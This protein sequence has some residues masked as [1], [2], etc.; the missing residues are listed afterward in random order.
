MANQS[1][2]D[3]FGQRSVDQVNKVKR[4]VCIKHNCPYLT[5]TDDGHSNYKPNTKAWLNNKC[6]NFSLITG[7]SRGCNPEDCKHWQDK[8]VKKRKARGICLRG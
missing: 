5:C 3:N 8:N 1:L 6:C 7:H 4:N 2:P